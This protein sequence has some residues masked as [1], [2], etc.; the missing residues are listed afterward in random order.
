MSAWIRLCCRLTTQGLPAGVKRAWGAPGHQAGSNDTAGDAAAL[1]AVEIMPRAIDHMETSY[2]M[3][4]G[5]GM[6][7]LIPIF[8]FLAGLR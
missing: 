8:C 2:R 1:I 3:R 6:Q 4:K 5:P 7:S